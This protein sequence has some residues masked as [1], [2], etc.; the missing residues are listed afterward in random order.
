M[1][2]ASRNVYE[3]RIAELGE[4]SEYTIHAGKNYAVKLHTANRGGEARELLAKLL[5]TSKLVLGRHH[6]TTK[7]VESTLECV[8]NESID[9]D[10]DHD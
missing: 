2:K 7:K 9:N 10:A 8:N 4:E 6:S 5:A 3:L 1:L